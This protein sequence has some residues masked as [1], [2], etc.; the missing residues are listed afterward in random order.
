LLFIIPLAQFL[1]TEIVISDDKLEAARRAFEH[2][3]PCRGKLSIYFSPVLCCQAD[4]PFFL[5]HKPFLL[6]LE[7]LVEVADIL[8]E[9]IDSYKPE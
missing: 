3:G 1:F 7:K 5:V 4:R 6:A 2:H 8:V 9:E